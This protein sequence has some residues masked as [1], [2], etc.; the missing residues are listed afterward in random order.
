MQR[1]IDISVVIPTKNRP[2]LLARAVRSA[3]TQTICNIEIIIVLDGPGESTIKAMALL[4]DLRIKLIALE[5]PVGGAEARN[6]GARAASGRYIALLDDDDEWLPTKLERQL[7]LADTSL[8]CC[9]VV[10][11]KYLYRLGGHPDEVWP[12]RLPHASEPLSEFLFSSCGGFQT[13]TYLCPRE[14]FLRVP[15][16]AGLPK[17]QDWDWFLRLAELPGFRVLV[18]PEPLSIYWAP[19][20]S[21]CTNVSKTNTW[22]WSHQWVQASKEMM[23]RRAYSMFLVKIC[24]RSARIQG[25]GVAQISSLL[26][27]LMVIGTPT[28]RFLLEFAVCVFVPEDLRRRL[29]YAWLASRRFFR[30]L[31]KPFLSVDRATPPAIIKDSL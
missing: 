23:T 31:G 27:D 25:A 30:S 14:L 29:R 8:D 24:V 4:T 13:S 11:T 17:H 9:F 28:P 12:K 2:D 5:R 22:Q 20:V 6:I 15:F 10:G 26:H 3:T 7:S 21:N 1:A 19:S 18:V 16:S